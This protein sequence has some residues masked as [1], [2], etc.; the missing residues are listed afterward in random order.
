[1]KVYSNTEVDSNKEIH[2]KKHS[3]KHPPAEKQN[4]GVGFVSAMFLIFYG[5]IRFLTEFFR[6]PDPFLGVLIFD[7]SMGQLLSLPLIALGLVIFL[8]SSGSEKSAA[9]K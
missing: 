5:I 6:E 7:L 2:R 3:K 1:M 4:K 9:L 8:Y